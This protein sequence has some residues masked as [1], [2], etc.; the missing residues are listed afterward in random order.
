M[1]GKQ[2]G[3][4]SGW[5]GRREAGWLGRERGV[6]GDFHPLGSIRKREA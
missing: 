5:V 1:D 3:R 4:T 2:G 6:A